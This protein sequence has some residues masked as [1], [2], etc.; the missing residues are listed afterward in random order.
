MVRQAH[1]ERTLTSASQV[2]NSVHAE[3]IEALEW[4]K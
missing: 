1:H 2:I 4:H 3:F